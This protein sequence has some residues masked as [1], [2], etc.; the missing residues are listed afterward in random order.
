ML[1]EVSAIVFLA[2]PGKD[3]GIELFVLFLLLDDLVD[4]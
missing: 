3:V 1:T 4:T 2:Q